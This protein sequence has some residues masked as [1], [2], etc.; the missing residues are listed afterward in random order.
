L[1]SLLVDGL[2]RLSDDKSHLAIIRVLVKLAQKESE[3]ESA[4]GKDKLWKV[5]I[6]TTHDELE[7]ASS[8][9]RT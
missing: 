3:D 8:P 4:E 2:F 1:I 7:R 6:K 5:I 9:S